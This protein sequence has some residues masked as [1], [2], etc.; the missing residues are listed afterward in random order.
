MKIQESFFSVFFSSL[1]SSACK[2]NG[3]LDFSYEMPQK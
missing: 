1:P 2:K 3:M